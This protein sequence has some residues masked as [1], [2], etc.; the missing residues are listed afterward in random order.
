MVNALESGPGL[1]LQA[2]AACSSPKS[3]GPQMDHST[4]LSLDVEPMVARRQRKAVASRGAAFVLPEVEEVVDR[5]M[6]GVP[7]ESVMGVDPGSGF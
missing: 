5:S 7:S 2:G 3:K 1:E 6:A 4:M